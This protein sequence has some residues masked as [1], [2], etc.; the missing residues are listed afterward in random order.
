MKCATEE[1]VCSRLNAIL[2]SCI[3]ELQERHT[4]DLMIEN[5][6][7]IKEAKGNHKSIIPDFCVTF[8]ERQHLEAKTIFVLEAKKSKSSSSLRADLK[9]L[10]DY[11][12]RLCLKDNYGSLCGVLTNYETWIF[13]RCNMM[14]EVAAVNQSSRRVR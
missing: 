12:R 3:H 7:I 4:L 11:L 6:K 10:C 8:K 2:M 9:Q 13:L 1:D 5:Q 14:T